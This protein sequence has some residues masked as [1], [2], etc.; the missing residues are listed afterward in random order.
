MGCT[1]QR[2][3]KGS[4]LIR[5]KKRKLWLSQWPEGNKR[6]S[7]KLGW[8]DEMTS[9]QAHRAH[10]QWMEKI[11]QEHEARLSPGIA[12]EEAYAVSEVHL[13]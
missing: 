13:P 10:R 5:G 8:W 11:N 9:S 2:D 1:R 3:R 4:L 6:L 7:H 12:V